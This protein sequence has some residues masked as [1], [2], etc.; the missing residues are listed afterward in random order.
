MVVVFAAAFVGPTT[1]TSRQ[2]GARFTPVGIT[3]MYD[4]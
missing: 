1:R 4:T 2:A 3:L